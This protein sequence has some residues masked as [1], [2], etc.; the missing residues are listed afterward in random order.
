MNKSWKWKRFGFFCGLVGVIAAFAVYVYGHIPP[1]TSGCMTQ[2]QIVSKNSRGDEVKM[3]DELCDGIAHSAT[4][5]LM[6]T[7][8]GTKTSEPFFIYD[9]DASYPPTFRW[10]DNTILQVNIDG[11]GPIYKQLDHVSDVAIRYS[12][13]LAP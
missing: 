9:I 3:S 11:E 8:K 6:L 4:T 5:T 10:T 2:Q 1:N 13:R 12:S 7:M